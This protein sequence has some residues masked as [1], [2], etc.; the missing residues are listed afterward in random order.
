MDLFW[1]TDGSSGRVMG[2]ASEDVE[3]LPSMERRQLR[4]FDS[5]VVVT[6]PTAGMRWKDELECV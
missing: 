4:N 2:A 3:A 1:M 5:V 6:G